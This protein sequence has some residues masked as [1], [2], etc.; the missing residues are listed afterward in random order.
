MKMGT[1]RWL[2]G[3]LVAIGLAGSAGAA[4]SATAD[5]AVAVALTNDWDNLVEDMRDAAEMARDDTNADEVLNAQDLP[6][7]H[8]GFFDD[9]GT[10]AGAGEVARQLCAGDML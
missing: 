8:L 7:I 5:V 1:V 2:G 3:L 6:P 4:S 9:R 10:A